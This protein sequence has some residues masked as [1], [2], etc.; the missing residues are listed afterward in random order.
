[1][2]INLLYALGM[3]LFVSC[4]SPKNLAYFS[5][6]PENSTYSEKITNETEPKIQPD[7]LLSI[8]V[9]SLN[10]EANALFNK[11][12]L[13][14]GN[15]SASGSNRISDEGYLVNSDGE[16]EF[17]VLGKVK[18]GGLTKEEARTKL[19]KELNKYLKDPAVNIRF[20]NF[21][22]TVI[23]EVND[24][25]TFTIPSEKINILEALGLAG[26]M[27]LYGKRE[28]VLLIREENG[29]RK[30]TRINLNSKDAFNS[31]YFYLQQND[32][33]YVEPNK[34]R[35]VQ[36]TTNTRNITLLFSVI[37]VTTLIISRLI[38]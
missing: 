25:A 7:D 3:L 17:P 31:P 10:P 11:G 26:D 37:S 38:R 16:I 29:I 2:K 27:T 15:N 8:T 12:V 28:N 4:T 33:V 13:L 24:P 21:R 5:D 36:A 30:M 35:Q 9:T 20:L 6:L 23:G 32:V 14:S 19:V 22:V 34:V 18:L 1:M